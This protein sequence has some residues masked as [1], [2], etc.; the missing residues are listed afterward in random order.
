M[1]IIDV[2]EGDITRVRVDAIVN[3]ANSTL[4][5][6]GGVDGAIHRAGG[7]DV[8]AQCKVLRNTSLPNGLAAG[9]A[10]ATTAGLLPAKWVIHAVGPRYSAHE[11]RS[12]ILR[13]AYIRSLAVAD[14]LGARTVA[15]PLISGGSYGWP[16]E[17]AV[18]QQLAAIVGAYSRVEVVSVV[19]FSARGAKLTTRLLS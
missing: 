18:A 16:L 17:D 6:G 13:A 3:A 9:G 11:D 8:L 5:G 19:A 7:P 2:I 12:G 1:T 14:S 10:V 4:L 15:F